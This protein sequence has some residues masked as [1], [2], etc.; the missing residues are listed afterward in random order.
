MRRVVVTGLGPV[1]PIGNG[2]EAFLRGQHEGRNGIRTI[3]RFDASELSVRIAGEVDFP[4]FIQGEA[5]KAALLE[6]FRQRV[7]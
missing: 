5:P 6:T 4:L 3:T 7:G 2:A 1:T